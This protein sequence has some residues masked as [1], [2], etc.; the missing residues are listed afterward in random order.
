[1]QAS[2]GVSLRLGKA[3]AMSKAEQLGANG[4]E[5]MRL[6]RLED[7]DLAGKKVFL[8]L[9]LNVPIKAG[10]IVDD[11][12]IKAAIPTV[13]YILE[14]AER[15]A[16]CTH[17]GRPKGEPDPA[18]SL[19]PVAERLGELLGVDV[20]FVSDYIEEPAVQVLNQL[21]KGQLM[22]LEN[23]RFYPG[24][25]KN[26]REFSRI[27]IEGFDLYVNDAFGT[28]HR[29]HASTVGAAE[30]LRPEQRAAGFLI[31]KEIGALTELLHSPKHPFTVVMGGS[32]VSDKIGVILNLMER[33]NHLLIGGA[34]A[35]TFL[36]FRG[37]SVGTS[38][39]EEEKMKMVESIYRNAEARKVQIHL[40][41]DH[42]CA[43]EFSDTAQPVEIGE[44]SIPEGLMGLDIG[45]KTI[46]AYQEIIQ[47]S[48]TVLWNGPMGVF[49]WK[50]YAKGSMAIAHAMAVCPGKTVIGGGDSVAAVNL[51]GVAEKM[52]HISTGGGASLEFLEGKTLPGIKILTH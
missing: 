28:A 50:A 49:E 7:L 42:V 5:N 18:F 47:S 11:T 13:E 21:D 43:K 30:I 27:L 20:A 1:M 52:S 23:V 17:L 22:L 46:E 41:V 33:C 40:P 48:Q 37:E 39:V 36:K 16:I 45:P 12:R 34:M 6:R 24:E 9:D 8:R 4:D 26:D 32:K 51:A 31:E 29:A 10:K 38:R 35:Y 15:L 44:A 2:L 19:E 25:T 14:R 3:S